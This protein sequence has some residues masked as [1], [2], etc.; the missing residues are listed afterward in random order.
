MVCPM[1]ENQP[2][3]TA[4]RRIRYLVSVQQPQKQEM[5]L[6][7]VQI[8]IHANVSVAFMCLCDVRTR[9]NATPTTGIYGTKQCAF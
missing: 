2:H 8:V 7:T 6:V 9:D 5:K 3:K 1:E 4:R